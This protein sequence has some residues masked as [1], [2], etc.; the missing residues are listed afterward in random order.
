MTDIVN[1]Q[2]VHDGD[3]DDEDVVVVVD[4]YGKPLRYQAEQTIEMAYL[5]GGIKGLDRYFEVTT[6]PKGNRK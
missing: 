3:N 6:G 4:R 5:L 2:F 1:G